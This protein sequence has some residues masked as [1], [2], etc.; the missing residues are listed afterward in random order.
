MHKLIARLMGSLF[1]RRHERSLP[2]ATWMLAGE[3]DITRLM[4]GLR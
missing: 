2:D 1:R 4:A 3:E